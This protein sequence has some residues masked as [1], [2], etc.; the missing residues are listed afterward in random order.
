M[1]CTMARVS[2]TGVY[3]SNVIMHNKNAYQDM[4]DG[5]GE[6]YRCILV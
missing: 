6:W 2:G 4:D 1:A 3:W 5:Q